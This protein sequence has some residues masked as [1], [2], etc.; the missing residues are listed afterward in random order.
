[1]QV[2][3]HPFRFIN[4]KVAHLDSDDDQFAA[5]RI[6]AAVLTSVG[7]LPIKPFF[8]SMD[9]EFM[10]FDI[11]GFV[12][13]ASNHLDGIIIEDITQTTTSEGTPKI[14]VSFTRT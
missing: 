8:G 1:M 4:G 6:A 11:G 5:Q 12:T 13:T 7:E 2:L 10:S 14:V 3:A 9:P